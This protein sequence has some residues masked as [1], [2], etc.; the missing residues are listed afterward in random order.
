MAG[1]E[2]HFISQVRSLADIVT[3]ISDYIPL[4]KQGKN[5]TGLC[6]FHKEKAPSFNVSREKQFFYCFGCH[7]GGDVF[8]F[9]SLYENVGFVEAVKL[10]ASR[11]GIPVP[12]STRSSDAFERKKEKIYEIHS[13]AAEFYMGCLDAKEGE[14]AREHLHSRGILK[15]FTEKLKIGFAPDAWDRLRGFFGKKGYRRG[16]L[17]ESGLFSKKKTG[18]GFYDRFRNRLMFPIFSPYGA[19]VGF[20]GRAISD[21][22]PKYLNSPETVVFHK[23][24]ILFGLNFA[25]EKI[26][27]TNEVIVVEGNFDLITLHQAGFTNTVAPLG[28]SFTAGHAELLGRYTKNIL[29]NFDQDEAGY[30]ATMRTLPIFLEQGFS[31]KIIGLPEGFDPDSC[32]REEGK[33]FYQ[34]K[35]IDA[36][37][38]ILY[39]IKKES[40]AR[41]SLKGKE[42]IE[43]VEKILPLIGRVKNKILM[44]EH[45]AQLA[46]FIDVDPR[47]LLSEIAG[48]KP[49]EEKVQPWTPLKTYMNRVSRA[50]KQVLY[51]MMHD[52]GIKK[53]VLPG[54]DPDWYIDSPL[55]HVFRVL[56]NRYKEKQDFNFNEFLSSLDDTEEKQI[57]LDIF[58]DDTNRIPEKDIQACLNIALSKKLEKEKKEIEKR[59]RAADSEKNCKQS[60][61]LLREHSEIQK[62]IL[63][64][65]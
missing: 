56:K 31:I 3:L 37:D 21:A 63:S 27:E 11:F 25:K 4:K 48:G 7:E 15:E 57:L 55:F 28:T 20:S 40:G 58:F 43:I 53:Q 10:I 19:I 6:P 17:E 45:T 24:K 13:L 42:K 18:E 30:R 64:L 35:I 46:E 39:V 61:D 54:M 52:E 62:Q 51:G 49:S 59:I 41:S 60:S 5:Y 26:R 14:K 32:I 22:E 33:E 2:P 9:V 47:L 38:A 50:E 36:M 23:S 8:K 44:Q 29:I 12:K 34:Q 16:D 65:K 1:F